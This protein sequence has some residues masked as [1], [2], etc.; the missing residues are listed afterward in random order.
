MKSK[1]LFISILTCSFSALKSQD[2]L[3]VMHYNLTY[4]D[5]YTTFCTTTNNNVNSKNGYLVTIMNYMKPDILTVNEMGRNMSGSVNTSATKFL[6]SVLN[7]GGVTYYKRADESGTA[8]LVNM[9]FYNSNKVEMYHHEL[10]TKDVNGV[11]LTRTIDEYTF[12]YK[13]PDLSTTHD[14]VQFT[15]IVAHLKAGSTQPDMDERN[16]E[17]QALMANLNQKNIRGNRMFMG[18]FNVE[19]ST[20]PCFQNLVNE[21]NTK[22]R[23]YDPINSLG[24][25][26]SNPSFKNA[27]SACKY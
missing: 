6:N 18:D 10:V 4:Y 19:A 2:T 16:S 13:A 3:K 21:P 25:W 23:F 27:C 8:S 24:S 5:E 22:V 14:T 12:Y 26:Y 1:L 9:I 17:T 11:N 7:T 20:E 15:C